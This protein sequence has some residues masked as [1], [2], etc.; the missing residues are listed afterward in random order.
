MHESKQPFAL[1][2]VPSLDGAVVG[3]MLFE[4]DFEPSLDSL[5]LKF[6]GSNNPWSQICSVC[7]LLF[8]AIY[9]K[10]LPTPVCFTLFFAHLKCITE[11]VTVCIIHIL[12]YID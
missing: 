1:P 12:K 7:C 6:R 10:L 11:F 8:K 4:N 2:H 9:E 5:L 3:E